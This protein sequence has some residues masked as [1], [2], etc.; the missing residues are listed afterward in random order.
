MSRYARILD[1]PPTLHPLDVRATLDELGVLEAED[2]HDGF[3]L[4]G[5]VA[6][7]RFADRWYWQES[8]LLPRLEV[9]SMVHLRDLVVE[10][11]AR[12]ALAA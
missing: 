8:E 3:D 5:G 7:F 2:L 12:L 9:T 11:H 6:V 4:L 1:D 10:L